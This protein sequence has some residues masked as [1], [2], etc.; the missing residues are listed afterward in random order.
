MAMIGLL[1]HEQEVFQKTELTTSA[2]ALLAV[3]FVIGGP[4]ARLTRVLL[5]GDIGST[6]WWE[7]L[8]G[9]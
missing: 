9:E 3:S 1:T 2:I 6:V 5:A 8:A 4:P 7:I